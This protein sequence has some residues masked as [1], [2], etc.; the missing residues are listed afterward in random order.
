MPGAQITCPGCDHPASEHVERMGC[1]RD[2]CRCLWVHVDV[3]ISEESWAAAT[4][5]VEA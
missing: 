4:A 1:A 3:H 2:T 5:P